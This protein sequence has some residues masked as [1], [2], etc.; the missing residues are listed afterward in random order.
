MLFST[1]PLLRIGWQ[2]C[3]ALCPDP[4][5]LVQLLVRLV[6]PLDCHAR[7][8][9]SY[10]C[11][12]LHPLASGPYASRSTPKVRPVYLHSI[13]CL[14]IS[15]PHCPPYS[16]GG[17]IAVLDIQAS[18]SQLT[19]RSLLHTLAH[20]A[21]AA[22]VPRFHLAI[23]PFPPGTHSLLRSYGSLHTYSAAASSIL[24]AVT[25]HSTPLRLDVYYISL[26]LQS[27]SAQYITT[28]T[29]GTFRHRTAGT[30][31]VPS[32]GHHSIGPQRGTGRVIF[33]GVDL[34]PAIR[35]GTVG[36]EA[37]GHK[38]PRRLAG[39]GS[40]PRFPGVLLPFL[41]QATKDYKQSGVLFLRGHEIVVGSSPA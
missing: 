3:S 41:C 4:A 18:P 33:I 1:A 6:Q 28:L 17:L 19:Y 12:V 14:S 25:A 39:L 26:Q 9:V 2:I 40:L 34:G 36:P 31:P 15:V 21:P 37:P 20:P 5:L 35:L 29:L 13:W 11:S 22:R 16:P 32:F 23:A 10:M 38:V 24:T 30:F 7:L 8:H 27:T